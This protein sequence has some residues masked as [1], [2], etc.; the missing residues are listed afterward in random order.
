MITHC[1]KKHGVE[2]DERLN[3][4]SSVEWHDDSREEGKVTESEQKSWS[5]LHTIRVRYR[6]IVTCKATVIWK[7]IVEQVRRH[8][9]HYLHKYMRK[10]YRQFCVVQIKTNVY[11]IGHVT[12]K[13]K[14]LFS[15]VV[16]IKWIKC[17]MTI[18]TIITA[19]IKEEK[20]CNAC[21]HLS[22]GIIHLFP[23]MQNHFN[24]ILILVN[25]FYLPFYIY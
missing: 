5:Q 11:D 24:L 22:T 18:K 12:L 7:Q 21:K 6:I 16:E 8:T 23:N 13:W 4:E 25:I 1:R 10:F 20:V 14:Q 2:I 17:F 15:T 9:W 3:V 19:W